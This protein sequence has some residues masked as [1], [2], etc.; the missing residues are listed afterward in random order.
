[1]LEG[2]VYLDEAVPGI[3]WDAKY[4]TSDNL[5]GKPLDGY[6]VNRVVGTVELA[7]GLNLAQAVFA[8]RGYC[9]FLF[10]AYRPVRAVRKFAEWAKRPEDFSTKEK[11]YPNHR[12]EDLFR[13]GYIAEKSGNSRGSSV[14]LTLTKNGAPLDMG[15]CFDRMDVSSHHS[16]PAP[17]PAR[18]NRR[19][20]RLGMEECGFTAYENEWWHYP[21]REEP[22]PDTWFDFP[23]E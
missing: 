15:G 14:D 5:T 2:F 23:I 8:R 9:L 21:L 1:M 16:F 13:L 11:H 6:R 17:E 12:K 19:L 4:A 22:Y 7:R 10:D 20:L 3:G 18:S